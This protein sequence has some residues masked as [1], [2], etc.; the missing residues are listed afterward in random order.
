MK[1]IIKYTALTILALS[2]YAC[3]DYLDEDPKGQ[4]MS[5]SAFSQPSDLD[6]AVHCLSYLCKWIGNYNSYASQGLLG[7]D[8]NSIT[9]KTKYLR[10]D[11]YEFNDNDD[12]VIDP[13]ERPWINI[14]CANFIINGGGDTPGV[15]ED[16]LNRDLGIAYFWRGYWYFFLVRTFGKLPMNIDNSIDLQKDLS[17]EAEVYEQIVSDLKTAEEMLPM[18]YDSDP[19]ATNGYNIAPNKAAAQATLAQVYLTMAGWPLNKGQEYYK[20]A[21]DEAKKLI[22]DVKAGKYYYALFENY[23]D[24]FSRKYNKAQK[25]SVLALYYD[26]SWGDGSSKPDSRACADAVTES[27]GYSNARCE[28]KFWLNFPPGPR[29]KATYGDVYYHNGDKKVVPWFYSNAIGYT[30]YMLKTMQADEGEF[31]QTVSWSKQSSYW[32]DQTRSLI[33]LSEVYLFYAEALGR[34]GQ[35]NQEAIDLVNIV[36]NRADGQ[37]VST[38]RADSSPNIYPDSMTAAQLAEAAYNEHGWETACYHYGCATRYFDM[39]RME[40][41]KEHFDYRKQNPAIEVTGQW[42][43]ENPDKAD[44]VTGPVSLKEPGEISVEWSEKLLYFP[45]PAF[46]KALNDKLKDADSIVE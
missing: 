8:I 28:L 29:K 6:G 39:R 3:K 36:R 33:R 4:L 22:D 27:G 20:L 32:G 2:L 21:A 14:K 23:G 9:T 25:E 1:N 17:S 31:D 38:T 42:L 40:R 41:V 24:N 35:V 30:P 12:L 44:M 15:T 10:Q 46:D 19:W 34:S 18:N 5:T 26:M 45:Y 13:W 16:Q 11:C 43:A 7:D 37:G